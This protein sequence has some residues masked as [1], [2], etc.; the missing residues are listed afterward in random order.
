MG[1]YP[2]MHALLDSAQPLPEAFAVAPYYEMALT[3]DHPQREIL[4]EAL[5]ALDALLRKINPDA[6]NSVSG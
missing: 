6:G 2:R 4:L 5:Q 3:A 1:P